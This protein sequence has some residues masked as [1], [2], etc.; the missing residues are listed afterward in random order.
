MQIRPRLV[1]SL[2]SVLLGLSALP[3]AHAAPAIMNG[4]FES[5]FANW[6]TLDQTGSEGT[7]Y[8]QKRHH[9]PDHRLHR[10]R[11][12]RGQP[13]G[14][15]RFRTGRPRHPC[16]VPGLRGQRGRCDPELRALHRQPGQR[17]LHPCHPGFRHHGHQPAGPR[18]HPQGRCRCLQRGFRRHPDDPLPDPGRGCARF[19]LHHHHP[20]HHR[21]AR[22]PQRRNPAPALCREPTTSTCSSWAWTTCA[23]RSRATR[24]RSRL[25]CCCSSVPW[26]RWP[27]PGAS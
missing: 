12:P 10:G 14:H 2:L 7:F 27:S 23:S 18:G 25:P 4:G 22:R 3:A 8:L 13:G 21:P 16:A 20:G 6:T 17:F 19:R 5:G 15:E 26:V 1:T 24:C 9:Q 11:A